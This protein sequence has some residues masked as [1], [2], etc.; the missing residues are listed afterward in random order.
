MI[1]DLLPQRRDP[2]S[3]PRRRGFGGLCAVPNGGRL[4][5]FKSDTSAKTIYWL[6]RL[7]AADVHH[8][9]TS[10][11][12]RPGSSWY[13]RASSSAY[14]VGS[15]GPASLRTSSAIPAGAIHGRLLTG[16]GGSRLVRVR[17][18]QA[19]S[20]RAARPVSSSPVTTGR[21]VHHGRPAGGG[22]RRQLLITPSPAV[23]EPRRPQ[24]RQPGSE[25]LQ[26]L[27][28]RPDQPTHPSGDIACGAMVACPL[29]YGI[30]NA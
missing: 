22:L 5:W 15:H 13:R 12:R 23:A 21:A 27:L 4:V 30:Y 10:A 8:L 20:T 28:P 16:V 1:Q 2:R 26:A 11:A 14:A 25:R 19:S 6:P 9:A 18:H 29:A 17:D 3:P 7:S 24:S